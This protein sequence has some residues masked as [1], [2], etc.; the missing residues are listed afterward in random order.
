MRRPASSPRTVRAPSGGAASLL[1]ALV[2]AGCSKPRTPDTTTMQTRDSAGVRIIEYTSLPAAPARWAV[3]SD[4]DLVIG[5]MEGDA[6]EEFGWISSVVQRSD[7]VIV[8]ADATNTELQAF[9]ASGRHLWTAGRKGDGPGEFRSIAA[10]SLLGGDSV[11]VFDGMARRNS[12][13]DPAG[14]VARSFHVEPPSLPGHSS[15]RVQLATID[16]SVLGLAYQS[17]RFPPPE[18]KYRIP[19]Q[20]VEY[21]PDGA[22]RAASREFSGSEYLTQH[23]P[24]GSWTS[25]S[26]RFGRSMQVA[27]RG[28]DIAVTTQD[29]FEIL[30][31][32]GIDALAMI[33]RV[34]VEPVAMDDAVRHR[35]VKDPGRGVVFPDVLPAMGRIR[36]DAA[37]Q[38]W[39]EQFVPP[40]QKQAPAWWVFDPQGQ[41][42]ATA[43]VPTSFSIHQIE[44]DHVI[45]V[46]QDSLG[47]SYVQVR[48]IL[49]GDR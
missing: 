21:G 36:I 38:L 34:D 32:H 14:R 2:M 49:K 17:A 8:V 48:R 35:L 15:T 29:R 37:G 6:S 4:P 20:V 16:G 9:D 44:A 24:N 13:F 22:L 19:A 31:Y 3:S 1:L 45:G 43:S 12:I 28:G 10:M 7:G 33:L 42:V 25:M 27:A 41:L 30:R 26:L 18:G 23:H 47:V 5:A 40:Y 11:I 39:V 46:V